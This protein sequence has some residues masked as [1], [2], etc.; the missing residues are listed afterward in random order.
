MKFGIS[1]FV[2]SIFALVGIIWIFQGI[3]VIKG[4]FMTGDLTWT[5]IGIVMEVL[6][7]GVFWF[8]TRRPKKI[9]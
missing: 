9:K 5:Y 6:A 2:A 7:V 4:S 8:G 1:I 3:G